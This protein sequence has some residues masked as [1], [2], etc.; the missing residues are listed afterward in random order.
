[1]TILGECETLSDCD[2]EQTEYLFDHSLFSPSKKSVETPSRIS[3]GACSR[4]DKFH[5]QALSPLEW[6]SQKVSKEKLKL[7]FG[8]SF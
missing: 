8:I 4:G 7:V 3:D 6:M 5:S 2:L 1:M